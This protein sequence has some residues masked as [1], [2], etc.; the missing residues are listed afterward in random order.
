MLQDHADQLGEGAAVKAAERGDMI[1]VP[2]RQLRTLEG[3]K[4]HVPPGSPGYSPM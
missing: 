1:L 4:Y 2:L 3:D